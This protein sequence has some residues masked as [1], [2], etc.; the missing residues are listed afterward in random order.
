MELAAVP[1]KIQTKRDL[2]KDFLSGD[3]TEE[4]AFSVIKRLGIFF[5]TWFMKK[6]HFMEVFRL[7]GGTTAT[8]ISLV[9]T[10]VS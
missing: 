7:E 10:V 6:N 5:V 4:V 8:I 1:G 9:A 2:H 3:V